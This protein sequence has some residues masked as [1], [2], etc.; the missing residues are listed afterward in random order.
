M[1]RALAESREVIR[2]VMVL[3]ANEKP[4]TPSIIMIAIYDFSNDVSGV[5]SP[6]P[7]V[8]MVVMQK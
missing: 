8:V 2:E 3:V 7:T 5:M 4:T 1:S 6:N